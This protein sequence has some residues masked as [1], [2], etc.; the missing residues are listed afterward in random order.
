[1]NKYCCFSMFHLIA[2]I[3]L[4]SNLYAKQENTNTTDIN[5]PPSIGNFALPTAQQPSPLVSFGQNIVDR[6][7]RQLFLEPTYIQAPMEH[8]TTATPSFL[9]GLYD[10]A[11]LYIS[12]PVAV[13]YREDTSHSSGLS[14][15]L[16]QLEYAFLETSNSR[17]TTQATF[18]TNTTLPTGSLEKSPPTGSGSPTFFL[19][20]TYNFTSVNWYGFVSPGAIFTP[21]HNNFKP[22]AQYFYQFGLGRNIH[23]TPNQYI[24]AGLVEFNG[25]IAE[26]SSIF[27]QA[28]PDTG[29]K[30]FGVTPSL[31]FSTQH[32][33][34]QVG[35][36]IPLV[37]H[38]NGDQ[39]PNDYF[40]VGNI[41]WL[42]SP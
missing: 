2:C 10:T 16:I 13:S 39:E 14:D 35:I 38:L 30:I 32:L 6:G 25:I 8:F 21:K 9:Y 18:V 3:L 20:T 28:I 29:G 36:G 23:S 17:Y 31:W 5:Q 7:Q 26:K 40:L 19:G 34:L 27:N 33:T 15:A 1:M 24:F 42:F 37:Q 41:G 4:Q 12:L 22:G 11:S